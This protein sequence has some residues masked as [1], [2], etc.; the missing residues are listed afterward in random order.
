[1]AT[2]GWRSLRVGDVA[3]LDVERVSV[4]ADREYDITGVLIAGRGL[5]RR[6]TI[7]GSETN[8]P[9]L[10]RL[11]HGQVVYRKLT[12]WEGPITVVPGEFDGTFVSSEFPTLTLDGTQIL[13]KYMG[14]IC[15]LPSFHDEMRLRSTGT[16]ERRNRLKPGDLLEINIDLPTIEAQQAIVDAVGAADDALRAAKEERAAGFALL[17]AAVERWLLPGGSWH[18][19]PEH[20][21]C[22]MLSDVADVR[23]GITKGRRTDEPLAP[24]PF[25]RAANVQDG[26]L[27]LDQIKT[28]DV[29]EGEVER[30]RLQPGDVLMVEGG[31]A[32][33]LGR[34]WLWNGQ[35]GDCLHQNHVFRARPRRD[36]ID[37]RFLAYAITASPARE[38][39]FDKAKKTT[40]LASI[41]KTQISGMPV[42]V[43]PLAEQRHIVDRLDS[44]RRAA[45]GAQRAVERASAMRAS[46]IAKL[47]SGERRLCETLA[48]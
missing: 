5:F 11:R 45:V 47:L 14:L 44:I 17:R 33:H 43:P 18:E 23:S 40:N 32:E 27:D 19:L 12:A 16:A 8:Y 15:Q 13:P 39:C 1:M 34:G 26:F 41:N 30:F 48:A 35:I 36:L 24:R 10:H 21:D 25:L 31:N 4:E 3:E 38:Y 6:E 2:N 42:P 7:K 46:L 22:R 37:P 28:I 29:T 9:A 20:W